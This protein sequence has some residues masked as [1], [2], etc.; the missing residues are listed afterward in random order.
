MTE[1]PQVTA[2]KKVRNA[3]IQFEPH[4]HWADGDRYSSQQ[5]AE[6]LRE[7]QEMIERYL[8]HLDSIPFQP[9]R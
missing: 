1:D 7:A 8:D 9:D 5:A 4:L 2:A 3:A 6:P